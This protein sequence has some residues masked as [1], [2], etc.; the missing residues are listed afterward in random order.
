MSLQS[1]TLGAALDVIAPDGSEIRLL[2]SVAGGSAVHCSLPPGGVSQAVQHHRVEEIW[3][4]L[5]GAGEVWRSLDG[6]ETVEAF[7]PGTALSIP[8]GTHFQFRNSGPG[9]LRFFICTMPPWAGDDDASPVPNHWQPR[10][11]G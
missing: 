4:C 6:Q 7:T 8:L 5:E 11:A 10:P 9:P 2:V 3:Y 1:K